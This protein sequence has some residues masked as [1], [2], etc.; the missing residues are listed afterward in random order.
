MSESMSSLFFSIRRYY[1]RTSAYI[2]LFWL[3]CKGQHRPFET[4]PAFFTCFYHEGTQ[5]R[6]KTFEGS[7]HLRRLT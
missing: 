7:S 1:V 3:H 5:A 6:I 2:Y 4:F